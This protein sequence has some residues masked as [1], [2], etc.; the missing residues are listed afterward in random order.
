MKKIVLST[1]VLLSSLL[2]G[3]GSYVPAPEPVPTPNVSSAPSQ[4]Y[5][6]LG[7]AA[8][9]TYGKKLKW[10]D[11]QAGQDRSGAIV[12]ILGYQ[13]MPNIAV[14][15]RLSYGAISTDFSKSLTA[16]VFLKPSYNVT[17]E[18]AIYGLVGFGWVKIDGKNGYGDIVK[19]VS[20]Q[21]GLGASYKMQ[22]N[23]DV[24]A[25]YT[26]LLHDKTAKTAMPD[27]SAKVSHEAL[28]VGVNY[29]F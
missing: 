29:H 10:F 12:G 6:G 27:G 3:G 5:A 13:F 4:F 25:D 15:G 20:P 26:W 11:G 1:A 8:V 9:S 28:T 21:I 2:Y 14:E 19:K 17:N 18:I 16:S 23:I 7:L 22:E 24:F